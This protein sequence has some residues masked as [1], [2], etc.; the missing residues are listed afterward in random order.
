VSKR[1]LVIGLGRFGFNIARAL[2]EMGQYVQ[3]VESD[4]ERVND[5]AP[6]LHR[7]IRA[8]TTDPAAVRALRVSDYDVVVVAIS[9][10]VESSIITCLNC[11]DMGAKILLATAK[12]QAHGRVLE[13]IGVDRVIYPHRDM[14][15][16]LA[17]SITTGGIIDY[18]RLS[19]EYGLAELTAP[20]TLV[21]HTLKEL[22]LT[23]RF[24]LNVLAIRRGRQVIVSPGADERILEGDVIVVIGD[25]RGISEL[26]GT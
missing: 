7:V 2:T 13:R 8:D 11:K 1:F 16:R 5:V 24:G 4:P 26:E 17:Y 15:A 6:I 18:I 21:N 12:H 10:D 9:D 3:C 23:H 25:A 14:G 19:E 22:N 20:A